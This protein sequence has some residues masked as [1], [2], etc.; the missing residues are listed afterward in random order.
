MGSRRKEVMKRVKGGRRRDGKENE[1]RALFCEV[2]LEE[3]RGK[4]KVKNTPPP[5]KKTNILK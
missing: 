1:G 3:A 5:T 4:E 2:V